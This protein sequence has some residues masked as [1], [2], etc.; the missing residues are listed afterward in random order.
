[1]STKTIATEY[2][3]SQWEKVIQEQKTS[4]VSVEAFCITAGIKESAYYYWQRKLR[5]KA[6]EELA[7][8]DKQ[9]HA[10]ANGVFIP[11]GWA[12]CETGEHMEQDKPVVVE[13]QGFRVTIETCTT[14]EQLIKIFRALKSSC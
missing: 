10:S 6:C 14:T 4:G 8:G 3:L 2:K 1:M 5:D 13:I 7:A 11:N 9:D 12:I